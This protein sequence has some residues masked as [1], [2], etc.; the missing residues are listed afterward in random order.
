VSIFTAG[1]NGWKAVSFVLLTTYSVLHNL[2]FSEC[3]LKNLE[4]LGT[5]VQDWKDRTQTRYLSRVIESQLLQ[6]LSPFF[7]P[8]GV[9]WDF[10][11]TDFR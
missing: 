8:C 9:Q 2:I 11:W 7:S 6:N 4:T 3:F 5:V 10:L 1:A